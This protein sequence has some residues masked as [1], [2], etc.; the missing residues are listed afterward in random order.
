MRVG[1]HSGAAVVPEMLYVLY[2]NS[3]VDVVQPSVFRAS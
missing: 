3:V 1:T 2:Q